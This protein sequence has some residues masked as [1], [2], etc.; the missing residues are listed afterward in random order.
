SWARIEIHDDGPG[1]PEEVRG[2]IFE[3]FFTTKEVGR[4]TG[5]GLAIARHVIVE[6]H[7]GRLDVETEVG[8]GT[9][10]IVRLP[11]ESAGEAAV[12]KS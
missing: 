4:G 9:K 10:F 12:E 7:A 2:K 5:Q 8:S 11:L 6:K 1:I 3:P